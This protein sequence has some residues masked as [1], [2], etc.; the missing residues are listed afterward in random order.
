MASVVFL[1]GV[2]VGGHR[3]VRPSEIAARLGRLG[4]VSVGAAGTF[5]VRKA[6]S[7]ARLRAAIRRQLP[8]AAHIIVCSASEIRA[9]AAADPFAAHRPRRDLVQFVS[10]LER[11]RRSPLASLP[12][13]LPPGGR[14]GLKVLGQHPRFVIGL[15]R[16]EMKA[17][18]HLGA[19][20]RLLACAMTTRSWST[21]L[22]VARL[23][24]PPA[25]SPA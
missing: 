1:K 23:L 12:L 10:I 3:R 13:Q 16:R 7:P 20:E 14:W 19:V 25:G 17:I 8:F 21:I 22:A 15:H 11:R 24:D 18:A 2:N 4:L 6:I 5:V 9:L